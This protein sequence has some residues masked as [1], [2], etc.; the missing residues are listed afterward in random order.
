MSFRFVIYGML[1]AAWSGPGIAWAGTS[2]SEDG[3]S[4][5]FFSPGIG[6][7]FDY[8]TNVYRSEQEAIPAGALFLVPSFEV[9]VVTPQTDWSLDGSSGLRKF[10]VVGEPEAT[11][12]V[13]RAQRLTNLDTYNEFNV[14]G[15]LEVLRGNPVGVQVTERGTLRNNS[16]DKD[17]ALAPFT[18]QFRNRATGAMRLSPGEAL[19]IY[20]GVVHLYD[21][22]RTPSS[23]GLVRFNNRET[24]GPTADL[25]WS[26]FPR[27]YWVVRGSYEEV[28]W[29]DTVVEV[30]DSESVG[31]LQNELALPDSNHFKVRAGIEGQFTSKVYFDFLVGKGTAIYDPASAPVNKIDMSLGSSVEGAD[32][33]L[34][35]TQLRYQPTKKTRLSFSYRKDFL[36]AFFTNYVKFD[37]FQASITGDYGSVLP[38][39][40]Y[41]TRVE[42]YE[43]DIFRKDIL[44]RLRGG[45]GVRLAESTRMDLG[46]GWQQ[47]ASSDVKVEYDDFN[48]SLGFHW[49]H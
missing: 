47:R 29:V 30:T 22:F 18:S 33:L 5:K 39:L 24:F 34:I 37:V 40:S 15:D 35:A 3:K 20:G 1:L 13:E 10:L 36:D 6:L 7:S 11:S 27:T 32:G 31:T 45:F 16:A 21:A 4:K 26:F 46:L 19:S 41:T 17:Y 38:T 2:E 49:S 23:E 14:G 25:K 48:V 12:G 43:G 42:T 9:G 28:R 8:R 44:S